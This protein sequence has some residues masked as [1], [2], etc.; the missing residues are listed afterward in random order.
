VKERT[1][2]KGSDAAACGPDC[3]CRENLPGADVVGTASAGHPRVYLDHAATTPVRPEVLEEM[4]PYFSGTFGNASSVHMFGQEARK[5][6]ED[7]RAAIAYAIGAN[8][9]EIH[10]TSGGTESANLAVKGVARAGRDKGNH[11]I[12]SQIEHHAVLNCFAALAD[13]GFDVTYLPVDASGI[14]SPDALAEA[15]REDTI[16]IS[17]MAANNE[18]GTL[19]PIEEMGEIAKRRGVPFHSD[20]VQAIGK[21]P[22]DVQALHVDLLSISGHKVYAPK[23][24]GALYVRM[25]TRIDPLFHGGHHERGKRPGTE[26]VAAAVGL[27]RAIGL[28]VGEMRHGSQYLAALRNRLERGLRGRIPGTRVNGDP[29]RRLP[30]ILNMSFAPVAGEALLLALDMR[31]IAVSTGSACTSGLLEPSHVLQAMGVEPGV[32][33]GSLRFSLGR[34]NTKDEIDFVVESLTEIVARLHRTAPLH[35]EQARG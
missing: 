8:P 13:E 30:N 24:I 17:V 12:T 14:V 26:N 27:A 7:A 10:L 15:I 31:G 5:A 2:N 29:R 21:V 33:Q 11:L 34:G 1:P 20:A 23:G 35:V 6:L 25:G 22:V 3:A 9:L 19:Q 28:A 4:L 16:L 32:A 18:T